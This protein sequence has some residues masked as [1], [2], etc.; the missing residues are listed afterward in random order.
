MLFCTHRQSEVWKLA[1]RVLV[2]QQGRKVA[3]GAPEHVRE[4]LLEPAQLC[5]TVP[6]EESA[7]ALECLRTGGFDAQGSGA[8]IWVEAGAGRKLEAI[9]LL[10]DGGVR[11]ID[12]DVEA[13]RGSSHTSPNHH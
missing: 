2:L 7:V 13:N 3:E 12:L 6:A 1:D 9:A 5:F 8:R 10:Q 4:Y 11:I